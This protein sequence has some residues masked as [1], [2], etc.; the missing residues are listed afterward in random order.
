M[1]PFKQLFLESLRLPGRN[2]YNSFHTFYHFGPDRP[3][4]YIDDMGDQ[5][6]AMQEAKKPHDVEGLPS[7]F[8]STSVVGASSLA[9]GRFELQDIA[10]RMGVDALHGDLLQHH[11]FDPEHRMKNMFSPFSQ[12]SNGRIIWPDGSIS[13]PE[14]DDE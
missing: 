6:L 10:D 4:Y 8:I 3:A 2:R 13:P 11:T 12:H 9:H 14:Y 7:D 1:K 5:Q